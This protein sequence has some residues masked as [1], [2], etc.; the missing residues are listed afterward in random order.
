[1][2]VLNASNL[3][4]EDAQTETYC[5]VFFS[6]KPT[7]IIKTANSAD[8]RNPQWNHLDKFVFQIDR[9]ELFDLKL[10]VQIFNS[11]I[12]QKTL[13]GENLYD[14]IEIFE[15][16]SEK[17]PIKL[18]LK[19]SEGE[20]GEFGEINLLVSWVPEGNPIPEFN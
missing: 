10:V 20:D 14:P 4:V 13:V 11:E 19:N 15:N 12:V 17:Q 9:S 1:M 18:K 6:N 5:I 7:K 2:Q 8:A 16:P 3:A